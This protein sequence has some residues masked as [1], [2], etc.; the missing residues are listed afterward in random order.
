LPGQVSES[1]VANLK[2][3]FSDEAKKSVFAEL[4]KENADRLEEILA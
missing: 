4:P 3:H 1:T 2:K